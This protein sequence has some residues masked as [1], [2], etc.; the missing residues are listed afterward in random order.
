[1]SD[2]ASP[3]AAAKIRHR[4]GVELPDGRGITFTL[5]TFRW[6]RWVGDTGYGTVSDGG[7]KKRWRCYQCPFGLINIYGRWGDVR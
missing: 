6:N 7:P 3:R 4:F 2:A 1:V 5:A